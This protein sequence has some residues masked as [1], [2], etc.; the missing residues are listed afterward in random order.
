MSIETRSIA[1]ERDHQVFNHP[2]SFGIVCID[3]EQNYFRNEKI[4]NLI[5]TLF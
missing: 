4:F 1:E 2:M 5:N 3:L